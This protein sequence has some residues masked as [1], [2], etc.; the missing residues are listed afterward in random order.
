MLT[1]DVKSIVIDAVKFAIK[2]HNNA[3]YSAAEAA[4]Y[5]RVSKRK[6]SDLTPYIK[7]SIVG[8]KKLFTKADLDEYVQENRI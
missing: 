8:G 7:H 2:T 3:P 5:L 6:F 1:E 4:E